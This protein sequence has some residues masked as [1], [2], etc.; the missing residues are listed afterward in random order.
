MQ[1]NVLIVA[2]YFTTIRPCCHMTCVVYPCC[3]I[4]ATKPL[5]VHNLEQQSYIIFNLNLIL[6]S[7]FCLPCLQDSFTYIQTPFDSHKEARGAL[8]FSDFHCL[9]IFSDGLKKWKITLNVHK[10]GCVRLWT[11][12]LWSFC[13]NEPGTI[14]GER[15]LTLPCMALSP[16][17]ALPSAM[18]ITKYKIE[19]KSAHYLN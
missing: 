14:C 8:G 4:K 1:E 12:S 2:N 5:I 15:S 19:H 9:T 11:W 18:L 10:N 6:A 3:L 17:S 16:S 7:G 13:N